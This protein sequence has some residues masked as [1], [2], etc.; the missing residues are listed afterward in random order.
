MVIYCT[1]YRYNFPFLDSDII[2]VKND[3]KVVTPLFEH[4]AHRDFLDSFFIIGLNFW[5]I[6]SLLFESQIR[7]A[8]ALIKG[9]ASGFTEND[10]KAW[11]GKRTRYRFDFIWFLECSPGT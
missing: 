2:Q 1:G 7:F 3:G 4:V 9:E 8:I 11:E 6:T 5:A 10:I